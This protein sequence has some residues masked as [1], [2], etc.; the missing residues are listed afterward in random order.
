MNSVSRKEYHRNYRKNN[1]EKFAGYELKKTKPYKKALE[2]K[3]KA[4]FERSFING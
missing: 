2:L 4:D 3:K 1:P